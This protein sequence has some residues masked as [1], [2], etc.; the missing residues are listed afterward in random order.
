MRKS[1][2]NKRNEIGDEH[3]AD[4]ITRLYGE[5]K[6]GEHVKIFDNEDFGFRRITVERPLRLNFAVTASGWPASKEASAFQPGHQQEA[7]GHASGQAE[8]AEGRSMQEAILRRCGRWQPRALSRTAR[9]SA[10]C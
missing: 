6:E 3:I 4:E 1:L 7:Q 8:I 5:F 2:G 9:R 10:S